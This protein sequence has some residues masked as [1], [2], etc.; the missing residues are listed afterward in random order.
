MARAVLPTTPML[1]SGT[2]KSRSL[3]VRC[4]KADREISADGRI[5]NRGFVDTHTHH[6]A[7]ADTAGFIRVPARQRSRGK[8]GPVA[9]AIRGDS[10]LRCVN[11][12]KSS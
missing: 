10:L 12:G 6:D 4:A 8:P 7:Q 9:K 3:A 2:L 11:C 5:V 1:R